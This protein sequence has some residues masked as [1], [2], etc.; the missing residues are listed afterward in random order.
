MADQTISHY[1]LVGR[2]VS[3]EELPD[4]DLFVDAVY[5]GA[6]GGQLSSSVSSAS[7][8]PLGEVLH[9]PVEL[10]IHPRGKARS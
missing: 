10:A 7:T 4:A 9:R 8:S 6:A 5:E 3:H 1:R 2:V